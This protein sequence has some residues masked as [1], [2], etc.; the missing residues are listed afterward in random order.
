MREYPG[1]ITRIIDADTFEVIV[2]LGFNTSMDIRVRLLGI[3]AP[4][5]RGAEKKAGIESLKFASQLIV[6]KSIGQWPV[7]IYT[8]KKDSFGRWLADIV[9]TDGT[10]LADELINNGYAVEY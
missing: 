3:D 2:D 7:T 6:Q 4:E 10:D 8:H 5:I 1:R 9:F